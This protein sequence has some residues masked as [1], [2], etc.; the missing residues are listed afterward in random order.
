[1]LKCYPLAWHT[2][3]RQDSH[4]PNGCRFQMGSPLLN[5]R[6]YAFNT[7]TSLFSIAGVVG[8][9][10][11]TIQ[12]E[13]TGWLQYA[14]NWGDQQLPESDSRQVCVFDQ[15]K[16]TDGPS[17]EHRSFL[18]VS[19]LNRLIIHD[20]VSFRPSH[21]ESSTHLVVRVWHKLRF[22]KYNIQERRR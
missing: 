6:A 8:T 19:D 7:S 20:H 12:A 4:R 16:W 10:N 3:I 13:G 17:G 1:M 5:Y 18:R 14:G 11:A 2:S 9:A 21:E 22:S 15:C